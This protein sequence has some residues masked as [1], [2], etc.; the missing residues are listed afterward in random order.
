MA[1]EVTLSPPRRAVAAALLFLAAAFLA[2]VSPGESGFT[3]RTFGVTEGIL[4]ILLSHVM[5]QRS[6]W[7]SP[8]GALRWIA[9]A[10]APASC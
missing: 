6:V 1:P 10:A 2:G 8:P 7:W 3:Y 4:A 5:L 9:V